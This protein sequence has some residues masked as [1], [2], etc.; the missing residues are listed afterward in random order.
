MLLAPVS[1]EQTGQISLVTRQADQD[2]L[3]PYPRFDAGGLTGR[4]EGVDDG[5]TD[6][7]VMIAGEQIVLSAQSQRPDSVLDAVV[8]DVVPPVEDIAAQARKQ[9]IGID[10]GP[11]HPGLRLELVRDGIHPLLELLDEGIRLPLAALLHFVGA[12]SRFAHLIF[13]LIQLAD[14]DDGFAR[15]YHV[16][17]PQ[18][19]YL[20]LYPVNTAPAVAC[21]LELSFLIEIIKPCF[22]YDV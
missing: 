13:D 18:L 7:R 17:I 16:R 4:E 19:N 2:V 8:V 1:G 20:L 5:G 3:K 10:Q 12:Q 9:R 6:C 22:Q 15:P 21:L 14:V 11:A